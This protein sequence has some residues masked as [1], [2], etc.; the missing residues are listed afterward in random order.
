MLLREMKGL[1]VFRGEY[2][3]R[4]EV[5]CTAGELSGEGISADGDGNPWSWNAEVFA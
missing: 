3:F 4:E 5:R 2:R 1:G